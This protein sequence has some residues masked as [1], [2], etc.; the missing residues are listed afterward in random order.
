MGF[1]IECE[2]MPYIIDGHNL[3]PK[4]PGMNLGM[5]DDELLLVEMLQ[6]FCRRRNKQ[7]DVYFDNA[8]AGGLKVQKYGAVTAFFTRAGLPADQA[9]HAR[10]R[11]LGREARNWSVV[12]SDRA[13]QGYARSVKAT[14]ISS[15][16]FAEILA[17]SMVEYGDE[18]AEN[19]EPSLT[20][21]EIDD[22]LSLFGDER[23]E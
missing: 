23:Q 14:V 3:I 2:D 13:V 12:S 21:S 19:E 1:V 20:P 8:P 9:I 10:L 11:R 18:P 22:W 16:S 15:E 17:E 5:V 6:D 7:V 4:L